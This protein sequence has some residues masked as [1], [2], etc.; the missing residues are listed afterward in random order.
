MRRLILAIAF[1]SLLL[2]GAQ[3][4]IPFNPQS[5]GGSVIFS[6]DCD[7]V[8]DWTDASSGGASVDA[9]AGQC[10]G[11]LA[12]DFEDASILRGPTDS[13]S[14]F[15]SMKGITISGGDANKVGCVFRAPG[16]PGIHYTV[17]FN[18]G[19]NNYAIENHTDGH[20]LDSEVKGVESC[21][22]TYADIGQNHFVGI[23][24]SGTSTSTAVSWWD[25][26]TSVPG[27]G[28]DIESPSTWTDPAATCECTSTNISDAAS[29]S[30]IDVAGDCGPEMT[31]K[32]TD[33]ITIDDFACGDTP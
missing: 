21:G 12:A 17:F 15:C 7:N 8:S 18:N 16:T 25:W 32:T 23:T 22:C 2:M 11:N 4:N 27:D 9:E 20:G 10:P 33:E 28:F 26:G 6:E 5:S 13:T 14:E 19:N 3:Y 24:V 31:G 29:L 30:L 1:C